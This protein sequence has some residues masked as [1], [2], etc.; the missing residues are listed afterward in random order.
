MLAR[1]DKIPLIITR[2][3]RY[4]AIT[5]VIYLWVIFFI[6][7]NIQLVSIANPITDLYQVWSLIKTFIS[8]LIIIP[9]VIWYG[10]LLV[11]LIDFL[12]T[13]EDSIEKSIRRTNLWNKVKI[14]IIYFPLSVLLLHNSWL[15]GW[16]VADICIVIYTTII[17]I[18]S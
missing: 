17:N 12:T 10:I 11:N 1:F 5:L 8:F 2:Y 6:D 18:F 4:S 7:T 15:V 9:W 3:T 16:I 14:M 13:P